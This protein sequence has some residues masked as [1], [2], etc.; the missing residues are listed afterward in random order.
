VRPEQARDNL[1]D[2]NAFFGEANG[3]VAYAAAAVRVDKPTPVRVE[4]GSDDGM[5]LWLNGKEI[6]AVHGSRRFKP[7][8][9]VFTARLEPGQ[10]RLLCR[11]EQGGGEWKFQLNLWD[12][13]GPAP[14]PLDSSP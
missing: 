9:D 13:S 10:N 5:V 11:I 14:R 3:V 12:L 6:R 4:C 2:L 7:G 8:E 1:I